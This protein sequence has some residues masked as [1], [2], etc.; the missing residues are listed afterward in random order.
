MSLSPQ[1]LSP[2]A[3]IS[4][5]TVHGVVYLMTNS[6]ARLCAKPTGDGVCVCKGPAKL[7]HYCTPPGDLACNALK[8]GQNVSLT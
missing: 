2:Q 8:T 6:D 5:I 4:C 7:T 1:A 3:L